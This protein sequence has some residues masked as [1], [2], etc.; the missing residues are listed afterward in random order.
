MS[1]RSSLQL[2]YYRVAYPYQSSTLI[3]I[4]S[5][6]FSPRC[7]LPAIYPADPSEHRIREAV[8]SMQG[9]VPRTGLSFAASDITL[10]K[11]DSQHG[12]GATGSQENDGFKTPTEPASVSQNRDMAKMR[13]QLDKLLQRLEQQRNGSR[14]QLEQQ[15]KENED[16]EERMERQM[17]QQREESKDQ[18]AR[19]MS[20]VSRLPASRD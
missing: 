17:E 1:K 3:T 9:P 14:E 13:G 5:V 12:S 4:S 19:L 7:S 8:G 20:I 11:D 2:R 10:G 18:M 6:L 15:K 16:K